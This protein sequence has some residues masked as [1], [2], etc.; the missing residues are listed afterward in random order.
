MESGARQTAASLVFLLAWLLVISPSD[1]SED[2]LRGYSGGSYVLLGMVFIAVQAVAIDL[3][4][5]LL[6]RV[7]GSRS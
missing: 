4:L 3:G 1:R 7:S 5:T 6:E 2:A